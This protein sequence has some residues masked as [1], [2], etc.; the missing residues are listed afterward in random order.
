[1]GTH[2]RRAFL[3]ILRETTMQRIV[4]RTDC[5]ALLVTD[6]ADV[7]YQRVVVA[8]D[9]SPAA[10]VVLRIGRTLSADDAPVQLIHALQIPYA[11]RIARSPE[12]MSQMETSFRKD[13]AA[14]DAAWRDTHD[15]TDLPPT[16]I[17]TTPILAALDTAPEGTKHTLIAVGAHG[18]VG[19]HRSVLGSVAVDLLRSPPCD[20]LVARPT[21]PH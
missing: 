21:T 15:L 11:G 10:A 8:T 3:D 20:V 7:P 14:S 1:M 19:A 18:R 16:D 2:R 5:A 17:V 12:L 4:R 6:P 9:F 13:A